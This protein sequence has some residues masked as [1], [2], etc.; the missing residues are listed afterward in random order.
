[1]P[2]CNPTLNILN[3]FH[4]NFTVCIDHAHIGACARSLRKSFVWN[5]KELF[6]QGALYRALPT[7]LVGAVP[8]AVIHYSILNFYINSFA[9]EGDMKKADG[10]TATLIG[11]WAECH[12]LFSPFAPLRL[13]KRTH[14]M[15]CASGLDILDH[16]G[17]QVS[18]P[19]ITPI[20]VLVV[21]IRMD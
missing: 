6:R 20:P 13:R 7:A 17:V 1:M 9:P 18:S 10:Q 11:S 16:K 12:K 4:I 2:W 5:F 14:D 19:F 21:R 15:K 8:K 3:W